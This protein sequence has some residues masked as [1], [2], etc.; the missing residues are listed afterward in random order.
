VGRAVSH[1]LPE[2]TAQLIAAEKDPRNRIE[3]VE[4]A[5]PRHNLV[6]GAAD[7]LQ[8]AAVDDRGLIADAAQTDLDLTVSKG[9]LP[10]AL[11][12]VGAL[13]NA[14]E[15]RGYEVGTGPTA[16][17]TGQI[18]RIDILEQLDTTW[19][20]PKEHDLDGPYEFGH[21]RFIQEAVPIRTP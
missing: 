3:V 13:L 6:A 17:I 7:S 12:L 11:L 2:A 15:S 10:R 19:E 18:I 5:N 1:T 16:L 8:R 4:W 9:S 21:S 14:L 20:L